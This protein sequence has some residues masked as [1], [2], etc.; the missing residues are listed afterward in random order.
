MYRV[1]VVDDEAF[2]RDLLVKNLSKSGLN[3]EIVAAASNGRA[4]LE[5]ALVLKPDIVI[6]DIAMA[7]MDGLEL[8]S[9]LQKAGLQC[10]TAIISGYDE[11]DYARRAISLGVRNYLLK[12]FLPKDLEQVVQ[13]MIQELDSQKTL[14]QNL[15]LLK[16][17]ANS[18]AAL[19]REK[20]LRDLLEG[21]KDVLRGEE[22]FSEAGLNL[23]GNLF[24][25]GVIRTS[26]N[27]WDFRSQK[28]AE[29]F[30]ILAGD[31]Y[32]PRDV[33][34][35]GVGFEENLLAVI[36]CGTGR[37]RAVFM[38]RIQEG[39]DRI[40]KS[41]KK[42]YDIQLNC[43]LG[44]VCDSLEGLEKS[45]GEA[46]ATWKKNLDGDRT[47]ILYDEEKRQDEL[48]NSQI[49]E[50]KDQICFSVRS[51]NQEE[52]LGHL[53]MLMKCYASL[54]SS[55]SDYIGVSAGELLYAIE[56]AV[57]SAGYDIEEAGTRDR[58]QERLRY[59]SLA[60]IRELLEQY[61][62]NCCS[63]VSRQLKENKAEALVKQIK[64]LIENNLKNEGMDLEW[65][66]MQMHF[67]TSY[68]R[69]I[70]KQ[71]TGE[72]LGEYLIRKRMEK[73][74]KLLQKT[75]LNIQEVA[76]ECGYGNQRYF[77]R[78]FKKFYGCTPT[79]FKQ[80]VEKEGLY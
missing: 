42:Y 15:R 13:K 40:N 52:A 58:I 20:V 76:E 69:Q 31:G 25:A 46:L 55:H 35:Y 26:G 41:L 47:V 24:L 28:A 80:A 33:R 51:G 8:I 72:A 71:Q 50:W 32:F 43:A 29:E 27:L 59:S 66:A 7:F 79:Q 1:M 68:V 70:F 45:Y 22:E 4:A 6:T 48:N 12:P 3:I 5:Q 61:I 78:S 62:E 63:Q 56:S 75:G 18:R 34:I 49:R 73:A 23:S 37:Q 60:D 44:E 77:A 57:N 21:R 16:E 14:Q 39:L 65:V 9:E 10:K 67:S 74:G 38:G 54:S 11:F 64:L 19:A 17:Q 2:V 53:R 30:L 36:W